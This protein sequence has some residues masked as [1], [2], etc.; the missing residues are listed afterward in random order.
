[1]PALH[2]ELLRATL[3]VSSSLIGGSSCVAARISIPSGGSP[4][5]CKLIT[6]DRSGQPEIPLPF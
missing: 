4:I 6:S 3:T 5:R 2:L 1:M